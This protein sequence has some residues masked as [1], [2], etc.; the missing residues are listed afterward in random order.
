[1]NYLW[2]NLFKKNGGEADYNQ[3]LKDTHIFQD[4]A[5]RELKFVRDMVHVRHY[6]SGEPVFRQGELGVGMYIVISGNIDIHVEDHTQDD[7]EKSS[8]YVTRLSRGE[9]FG[10]VSLVEEN[11]RRTATALSVDDAILMGLFQPDLME[12]IERNPSTGVKIVLRLAEVLGRRLKETSA[13]VSELKR[14]L[15]NLTEKA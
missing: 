13:R 2:D 9:F 4:L 15:K 7:P 1:M 12:I 14:E 8:I 5:P 3:I 11:S 6:K 10:E